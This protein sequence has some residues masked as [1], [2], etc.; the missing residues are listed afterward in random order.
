[1]NANEMTYIPAPNETRR[2]LE[3]LGVRAHGVRRLLP[4]GQRRPQLV[5]QQRVARPNLQRRT[6]A[7]RRL[8]KLSCNK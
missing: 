8:L 4:V 5:P 2:L 3:G 7:V 1:M 6:E